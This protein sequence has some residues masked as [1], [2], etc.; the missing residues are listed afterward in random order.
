M[1]QLQIIGKLNDNLASEI[2]LAMFNDIKSSND[3]A[4]SNKE[5]ERLIKIE[6]DLVSYQLYLESIAKFFQRTIYY[7]LG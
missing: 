1:K 5:N 4:L 7:I 3:L 2:I 6:K